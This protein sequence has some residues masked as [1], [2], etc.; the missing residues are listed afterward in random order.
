MQLSRKVYTPSSPENQV[1]LSIYVIAAPS[2]TTFIFK[3]KNSFS[4]QQNCA[5]V[6]LIAALFCIQG[7]TESRVCVLLKV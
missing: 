1:L 7:K 2:Y 5:H 6:Y 3:C 4:Q